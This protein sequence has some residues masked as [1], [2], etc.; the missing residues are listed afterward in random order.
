MN[1]GV[2]ARGLVEH[3]LKPA[4]DQRQRGDSSGLKFGQRF[5]LPLGSEQDLFLPHSLSKF[6][7]IHIPVSGHNSQNRLAAPYSFANN[8][9]KDDFG[10][11]AKP[12]GGALRP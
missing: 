1:F 2:I 3:C 10:R 6:F 9:F 5:R 7:Q 4:L 11:H 8:C 12:F